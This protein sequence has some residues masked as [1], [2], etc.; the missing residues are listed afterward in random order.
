MRCAFSPEGLA[1]MAQHDLSFLL[2]LPDC[3]TAQ[4]CPSLL[5]CR[6]SLTMKQDTNVEL[7]M[8]DVCPADIPHKS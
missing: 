3:S 8:Y 4:A 7:L 6:W 1:E 2:M 5:V